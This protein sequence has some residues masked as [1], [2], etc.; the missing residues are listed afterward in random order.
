MSTGKYLQRYDKRTDKE[1]RIWRWVFI[2][3]MTL[4]LVSACGSPSPSDTPDPTPTNVAASGSIEGFVW[5]DLC[6]N[7]DAGGTP[8]AGCIVDLASGVFRANGIAEPDE[9]G[10]ANVEIRLG[11]GTCPSS[12]LKTFVTTPDGRY[13]FSDLTPGIYCVL[14]VDATLEAGS[15]TSQLAESVDA[16][17][18]T[19]VV[20]G[21]DARIE[22]INFGWDF[23]ALPD[24]APPTDEPPIQPTPPD[25]CEDAASFVKD[26]SIPDG[27]RFD[28]GESFTKTWRLKNEGTCTWTTD[29]D[30]YFISGY[31]LGGPGVEALQ[32]DVSPGKTVD[33]S[34]EF[35]APTSDGTYKGFWMLRNKDSDL[36]GTGE[37]ANSPIWV[38]IIVGPEPEPDITEWRGEYFDNQE[39]KGDPVLV[40]NDKDIDFDWRRGAPTDELPAD[41]FSTR[42]TRTLKFDRSLYRFHLTMDDGASLWIDD[43]LVIDEWRLGS[44]REVTLDVHLTE[45]EHDIKLEYYERTGVAHVELWWEKATL[46]AGTGWRAM[47]WFNRALSSSFAIVETV[48][49]IDFDWGSGFPALG[50]SSDLF[51]AR[52][53]RKASFEPGTYRLFAQADDGVR[54]YVDDLLVL[55]EWHDSGGDIIHTADVILDGDHIV[56]V[57]YYE[58]KGDAKILFWWEL[59]ELQNDPPVSLNDAYS[60]TVNQ[61]LAVPAPGVLTNDSDPDDDDLQALLTK[62]TSHGTLSLNGDGSFIYTPDPGFTGEDV[63]RYRAT[64]GQ[65][66]SSAAKV[67]ITIHPPNSPPT[68]RNDRYNLDEDDVLSVAA[69][70]VLQ[71]DQD[72][73]GDPLTVTLEKGPE[74]GTLALNSDGSFIYTPSPDFNGQDSFSYRAN[75]GLHESAPANVRLNV[76]PVNDVPVANNDSA[77]LEGLSTID[78]NVLSNDKGLGDKPITVTI[79][80]PP[81]EGIATVIGNLIRYEAFGGIGGTDSLRYAVTDADGE[82]AQAVLSIQLSFNRP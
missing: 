51:S 72:P 74:H 47:Y 18:S 40:R 31:S 26:V 50:I 16:P 28:G 43:R 34:I 22:N 4:L 52:W 68:A 13:H 24:K 32:G 30:L 46:P 11:A 60:I 29:Y 5:H 10:L 25:T 64:D 73:D 20:V 79:I 1:T 81:L 14:A 23:L 3:V 78:I 19:T 63:F 2:G 49:L 15:W 27:T 45:G 61:T 58:R 8:P 9:P 77:S 44:D 35:K 12:N 53:R 82:S 75:D 55:D 65:L 67:T 66:K 33:I 80:D 56:R 76:A 48:E 36:F 54:I 38:S 59:I 70:G 21:T 42:W 17:G 41:H 71:N 62:G 69:P 37:D 57:E 39:L 7:G 6:V